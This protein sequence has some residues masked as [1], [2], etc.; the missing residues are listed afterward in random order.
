V[1][2]TLNTCDQAVRIERRAQ[3]AAISALDRCIGAEDLGF[4]LLDICWSGYMT[5]KKRGLGRGLDSLLGAAHTP[6]SVEEVEQGMLRQLPIDLVK[7]G[8]YQPRSRI[9]EGG[10]QELAESIRAQGVLQPIVVRPL[11][12]SRYEIVAGERRW[13][14]SQL[15][16]LDTIPAVVREVTDQAAIAIALIENIQREDLNPLEEA[17]ALHRL[18]TEFQMTHQEV[19]QALGRSRTTVTNLL[20]LL[21]LNEDVKRM[22]EQ[23]ELDMGHAR[24]LLAVPGGAQSQLAHRVAAQGLSVRETEQLVRLHQAPTVRQD[25]RAD[26][27]DPNVRHLQDQLT[28]RLGASVRIVHGSAGKGKLVISYSSLDELDGILGRIR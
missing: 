13:R 20:R 3:G 17:R 19:A 25:N 5:V 8:R 10:L 28:E 1:P 11:D 14:A 26:I 16:E 27:L 6:P 9:D 2:Q 23:G 12:D 22:V 7:R 21:E 4:A 18:L 15:A 24:A